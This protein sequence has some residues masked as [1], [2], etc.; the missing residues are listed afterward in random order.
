MLLLNTWA[1]GVCVRRSRCT[2]ISAGNCVRCDRAVLSEEAEL[3]E[4][5]NDPIKHVMGALCEKSHGI[6]V[7]K[8]GA[9]S[10]V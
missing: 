2:S 9:S 6:V 3:A 5:N 1:V 4:D 7:K 10:N 8:D